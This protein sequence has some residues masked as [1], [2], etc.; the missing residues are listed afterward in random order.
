MPYDEKLADRIRK[1]IP[2]GKTYSEKRMFGGLAF[3]LDG[4]MQIAAS[5]KGGILVRV[6]PDKSEEFVIDKNV[7]IAIMRGKEM[8]GW[9]RV[10][11]ENLSTKAKL[12]KWFDLSLSYVESLPPK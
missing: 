6:H 2:I 5:G 7:E 8:K 11:E 1:L 3:L 9:L 4:H 12:K 10:T